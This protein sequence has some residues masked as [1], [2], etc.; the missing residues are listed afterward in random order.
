VYGPGE[1]YC[2]NPLVTALLGI[3]YLFTAGKAIAGNSE[4]GIC[5]IRCGPED[6]IIES[7]YVVF[8]TGETDVHLCA[9]ILSYNEQTMIRVLL[10]SEIP[11]VGKKHLNSQYYFGNMFLH[12]IIQDNKKWRWTLRSL[13]KPKN[14]KIMTCCR[15]CSLFKE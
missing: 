15:C 6:K 13:P 7:S 3:H 9:S 10:G 1:E 12:E 11:Y 8:W 2:N 14:E 4:V 5:S